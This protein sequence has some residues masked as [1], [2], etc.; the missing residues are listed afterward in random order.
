[1]YRYGQIPVKLKLQ[2]PPPG[3]PRAFELLNTPPISTE[4]HYTSPQRQISSL[5]K[6]CSRFQREICP[7]DTFKLL[8]KTLLKELFANKGKFLSCKS[9]IPCKNRK[10]S[11]AYYT[12][13]R[14]KSGSNSPPFQRNVQIPPSLGT[15]HSQKCP[16]GMLK[17]QFERYIIFMRVLKGAGICLF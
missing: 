14:D 7:Y 8:L 5:I 16:W 10:N 2:N 4:I 3:N 17:L 9:I 15:M 6:H 1:M 13:T 12:T 11:W